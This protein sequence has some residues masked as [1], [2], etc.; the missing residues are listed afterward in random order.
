MTRPYKNMYD[1][2]HFLRYERYELRFQ[3]AFQRVYLCLLL[4]PMS[5][6]WLFHAL[7]PPEQAFFFKHDI[8]RPPPFCLSAAKK[9]HWSLQDQLPICP[10]WR[11]GRKTG[12]VRQ[13]IAGN[14][15]VPTSFEAGK[16]PSICTES[17]SER[18]TLPLAN[19]FPCYCS[20]SFRVQEGVNGRSDLCKINE[21]LQ[22]TS[23]PSS[24]PK[25]PS[26]FNEETCD[27]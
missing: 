22:F 9:A 21:C 12:R 17:E 19:S 8:V 10:S 23:D 5:S 11:Q 1:C 2:T 16:K 27:L 6:A 14:S 7:D 4:I 24:M 13:P 20:Y 18:S 25:Q 26:I 15:P 3:A